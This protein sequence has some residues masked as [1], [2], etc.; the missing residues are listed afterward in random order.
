MS[1][2]KEIRWL[3]EAGGEE[4]AIRYIGDREGHKWV[5]VE[6]TRK[7]GQ[8]DCHMFACIVF[9]DGKWVIPPEDQNIDFYLG[10]KTRQAVE[11]YLNKHGL[12]EG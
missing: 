10:K 6:E 3:F 11:D 4:W 12:P 5:E 7:N 9:H 2:K 1:Y 8:E